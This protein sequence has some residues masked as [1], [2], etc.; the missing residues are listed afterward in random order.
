MEGARKPFPT[1]FAHRGGTSLVVY[2]AAGLINYSGSNLVMIIK[3]E[4]PTTAAQLV[5]HDAIGNFC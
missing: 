2:P 3:S 5:I 4:C 1:G